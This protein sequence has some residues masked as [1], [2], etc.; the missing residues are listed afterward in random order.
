MRKYKN[1]RVDIGTLDPI[2]SY[3]IKSISQHLE[4]IT[5]EY[6][7]S[8]VT[9]FVLCPFFFAVVNS[10]THTHTHTKTEHSMESKWLQCPALGSTCY[11]PL[12]LL[13]GE[14]E[15]WDNG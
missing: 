5:R 1:I 8:K 10:N 15:R 7:E 4:N 6:E 11:N 3:K 12:V 2:E 9:L 14:A 13:Q